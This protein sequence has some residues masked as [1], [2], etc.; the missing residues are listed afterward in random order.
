MDIN[1]NMRR[2][3]R[4][5]VRD[6]ASMKDFNAALWQEYFY[7]QQHKASPNSIFP[8]FN[9]N[10]TDGSLERRGFTVSWNEMPSVSPTSGRSTAATDDINNENDDFISFSHRPVREVL[11]GTEVDEADDEI[12]NL[13]ALPHMVEQRK[14][15]TEAKALSQAPP[16]EEYLKFKRRQRAVGTQKKA[17]KA[18]QKK[19]AAVDAQEGNAVELEDNTS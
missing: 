1:N 6:K 15:I 17:S 5:Q 4:G 16:T 2:K 8:T 3:Y 10:A 13:I 9:Y 7:Q 18:E 19:E 11:S 14:R 12:Q